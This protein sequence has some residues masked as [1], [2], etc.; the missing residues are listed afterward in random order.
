MPTQAPPPQFPSRPHTHSR[1]HPL[2]SYAD[3]LAWD[4]SRGPTPEVQV[5][6]PTPRPRI[7]QDYPFSDTK[8]LA[9]PSHYPQTTTGKRPIVID[10]MSEEEEVQKEK[11][12][13][14]KPNASYGVG[15]TKMSTPPL[16]QM[17][18]LGPKNISGSSFKISTSWTMK[19][20]RG[21]QM[22]S[23]T[24]S[25][26]P[27]KLRVLTQGHPQAEQLMYH[28]KSL[29]R[30]IKIPPPLTPQEEVPPPLLQIVT[31]ITATGDLISTRTAWVPWDSVMMED[32]GRLITHSE[33]TDRPLSP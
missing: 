17:K 20:K 5:Q 33:M 12:L 8:C 26:G 27:S 24:N 32:T 16:D 11:S 31:L 3:V 30:H 19:A 18:G 22:M 25:S 23:S 6:P 7:R 14:P 21:G 28:M 29:H 10:L 1:S 13:T 9:P 15:S 2:P 4:P